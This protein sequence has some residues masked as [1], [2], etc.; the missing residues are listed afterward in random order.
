MDGLLCSFGHLDKYGVKLGHMYIGGLANAV[1]LSL[2]LSSCGT[3]TML[4][5][6]CAVLLNKMAWCC[7]CCST[8][9]PWFWCDSNRYV[10][11]NQIS[12]IRKVS[13]KHWKQPLSQRC[14]NHHGC[15][16]RRHDFTQDPTGSKKR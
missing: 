7:V 1:D 13:R 10:I 9:T 11:L 2:S 14:F 8:T 3:Q 15:L 12:L 4:N 5:P 16:D 6:N